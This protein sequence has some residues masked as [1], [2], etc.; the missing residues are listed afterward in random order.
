MPSLRPASTLAR[1]DA[2]GSF[3]VNFLH[4]KVTGDFICHERGQLVEQ[5]TEILCA[6][7]FVPHEG[8]L[9][10]NERMV[11]ND[12]VLHVVFHC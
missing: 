7:V 2:T 9:V 5:H 1:I 3:N 8:E 10:L 11:D 12:N 4:G 6:G